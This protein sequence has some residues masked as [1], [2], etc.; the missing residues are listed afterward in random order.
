MPRHQRTNQQPN[1]YRSRDIIQDRWARRAEDAARRAQSFRDLHQFVEHVVGPWAT[2]ARISQ[3]IAEDFDDMALDRSVKDAAQ[4][5]SFG[6]FNTVGN[7]PQVGHA[8]FVQIAPSRVKS[9]SHG[10]GGGNNVIHRGLTEQEF[11]RGR[12]A[13]R[14]YCTVFSEVVV[15]KGGVTPY[16]D[17]HQDPHTGAIRIYTGD[18]S[19]PIL[20]VNAGQPLRAIKWLEK[21]KVEKKPGAKPLIRSFCLPVA[22]YLS[23]TKSAILEHD[24]G[25]SRNRMKSFNVDR[26]YASDQFGLRG[27]G[28]RILKEKA[29]AHSLITYTDDTSY[30]RPALGGQ[31]VSTKVLRQRLGVPEET[32]PGVWVDSETG[33]FAKK[34]KFTGVADKLMN[35]YG[36]WFAN[37]QFIADAWSRIPRLR[38]LALMRE[39]LGEYKL[40]IADEFW[41][42]ILSGASPAVVAKSLVR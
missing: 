3:L 19:N 33:E 11:F 14:M 24:A 16:K 15:P 18:Q 29:I 21:Y 35:I 34:D 2:Q 32:I 5:I 17:I 13:V 7:T 23:I 10:G 38:R 22:D 4:K 30:S 26:H 41:Q 42:R 20:W 28:L 40:Y 36:T 37:E 31:I 25:H 8:L 39:Y 1:A 9:Q 27:E 12:P 6:R